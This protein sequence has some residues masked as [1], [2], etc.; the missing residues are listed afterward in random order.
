MKKQRALPQ[1]SE[2]HFSTLLP[3]SRCPCPGRTWRIP[4]SS[5]SFF[6]QFLLPRWFSSFPFSLL[7]LCR[8]PSVFYPFSI[9][10]LNSLFP[11]FFFSSFPS[12][13]SQ[14]LAV[15]PDWFFI[16]VRHFIPSLPLLYP[17]PRFDPVLLFPAAHPFPCPDPAPVYSY[18]LSHCVRPIQNWIRE[19]VRGVSDHQER[20]KAFP[21]A[22]MNRMIIVYMYTVQG[23]RL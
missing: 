18:M 14:M 17:S 20:P 13:G 19:R 1:E 15:Q 10:S 12:F 3:T 9:S 16:A 23:N 4:C 6:L 11:I 5:I 21:M 22:H 7:L 2:V 8:P